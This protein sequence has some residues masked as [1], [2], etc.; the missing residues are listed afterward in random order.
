MFS[1]QYVRNEQ[2]ETCRQ[3][4][5][6]KLVDGEDVFQ[7]VDPL[8]HGAGVEVVVDSSTDAPQRPHGVH[9]QWHAEAGRE[10]KLQHRLEQ[11]HE[12][13]QDLKLYLVMFYKLECSKSHRDGVL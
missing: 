12:T 7:R 9:H 6:H 8:L 5:N 1:P 4:R 11:E 10:A 3:G 13:H 2:D